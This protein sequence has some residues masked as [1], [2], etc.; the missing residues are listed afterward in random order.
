MIMKIKEKEGVLGRK[1]Y[2][3]EMYELD[4]FELFVEQDTDNEN[5]DGGEDL[6]ARNNPTNEINKAK[7]QDSENYRTSPLYQPSKP[8]KLQFLGQSVFPLLQLEYKMGIF[9]ILKVMF[10]ITQF[11]VMAG[12]L[13]SILQLTPPLI[14]Q[15]QLQLQLRTKQQM[16]VDE[17]TS[18]FIL[19]EKLS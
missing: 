18:L 3:D 19:E 7:C 2:E 17:E 8:T 5:S 10:A 1:F 15:L 12:T 9:K 11:L 16:V 4:R 6:E 14:I 13:I